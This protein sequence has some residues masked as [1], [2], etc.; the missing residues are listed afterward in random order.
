V[1]PAR[2]CFLTA[3]VDVQA[4]RLECEVVAWGRNK[5]S[6]SIAYEVIQPLASDGK[7]PLPSTAPEVWAELDRKILQRDWKHESG[8]TLPILLMAVDTGFVPE[9]VY[10]FC[11]KHPQLAYSPTGGMRVRAPRSVVPV[12]GDDNELK[13]ISTV[14]TDNAARKRHNIRIASVGTHC[15]KSELYDNLR[16]VLPLEN[17]CVPNCI[18]F[19][20]GYEMDYFK[21]LCSEHRLVKPNGDHTWEKKPNARN[22]PLDLKVYNRAAATLCGIDSFQAHHWAVM[23][24]RLVV[25]P[26]LPTEP[27]PAP[28]APTPKPRPMI[29]PPPTPRRQ[30]RRLFL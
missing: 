8:A 21:G 15:V 1:V 9:A 19:P 22:E 5:E 25:Q 7:T 30:T 10:Q 29:G 27:A 12:K 16:N 24:S 11:L 6:W 3:S 28:V 14:S 26:A 23:E 18:H 20:I 13:I 17:V 4:D 2:A